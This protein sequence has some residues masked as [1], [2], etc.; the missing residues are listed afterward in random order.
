MQSEME[1]ST[2]ETKRNESEA[3]IGYARIFARED[4]SLIEQGKNEKKEKMN[5]KTTRQ[6]F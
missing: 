4:R 5:E 6:S 2:N 3:V 1:L